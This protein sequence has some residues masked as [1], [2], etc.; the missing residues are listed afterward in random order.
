MSQ[1]A[2]PRYAVLA[3]GMPPRECLGE[4]QPADVASEAH[5]PVFDRSQPA[6]LPYQRRCRLIPIGELD[7]DG[8]GVSAEAS[9]LGLAYSSA[10]LKSTAMYGSSPTTH[11]S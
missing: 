7:V 6:E 1:R 4:T 2:A 9:H 3:S 8:P 10:P 5:G 11:A